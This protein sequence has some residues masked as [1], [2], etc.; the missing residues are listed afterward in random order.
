MRS[1]PEAFLFRKVKF[2][3]GTDKL[4]RSVESERCIV[5]PPRLR[6][7]NDRAADESDTNLA[8]RITHGAMTRAGGRFHLV[9]LAD[10]ASR[11][12]SIERN[13]RQYRKLCPLGVRPLQRVA[14]AANGIAVG[15]HH[16]D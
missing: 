4:T 3:I 12:P 2:A 13:L 6:I 16:P 1:L 15:E 8:C 5:T 7:T 9:I 14:Q 10:F 11:R